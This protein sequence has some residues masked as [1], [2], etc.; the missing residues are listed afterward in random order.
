MNISEGIKQTFE[1][2]SSNKLRSFLTMLGINFGVASLIAISIVGLSFRQFITDY[3]GQYG[4]Q[5]I[6]VQVNYGAYVQ[7]ESRT[8]MNQRDIDHFKKTLPGLTHYSTISQTSTWASHKGTKKQIPILGVDPDHFDIFAIKID[9]GRFFLEQEIKLNRAVC[10]IR[11]DIA[12]Q[13]F[14][15]Q[16]PL[17]QY[18]NIF[19][20]L[21]MVVGIT[22]RYEMGI[23]SDGS[24]NNSI[25]IPSNYVLS[26]IWGGQSFKYDVFVMKLD[27]M[28][29]VDRAVIRIENYLENKYGRIRDEKRFNIEKFDSFIQLTQTILNIISILIL[30]IAG[31]S[32]IVG[33]FGIVNIMLITVTERTREIGV[34]MAVGANR[35]DIL[36]QF[37]IEAV[38]LCLIGGGVGVIFGMGLAFLACLIL[39]WAFILNM[40]FVLLA[41]I[42]S[43]AIGLIFGIYPAY[44]ASKLMPMVA[45]R[46][47]Y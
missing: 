33:G 31:I 20:K 25:F 26:R 10:V 42:I 22:E 41:I 14:A 19:G 12:Q 27:N 5:L 8:L 45:L 36:F 47:E 1:V 29:N 44:K 17:G 43:T 4:S 39:E 13:L 38:T 46:I 34:R 40:L 21:F 35:Y 2:I 9:E 24:D 30:V 11:P 15:E 28:E 16:D 23:L 7:G 32:L 18:I 3:M 6:W 37:L